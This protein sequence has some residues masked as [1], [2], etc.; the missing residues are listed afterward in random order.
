MDGT[1]GIWKVEAPNSVFRTLEGPGSD[2]NWMEW[3]PKG[4]AIVAGSED[5]T[6][7]VWDLAKPLAI[8]QGFEAPSKMGGFSPNGYLVYSAG[9]DGSV[10]VWNM[11]EVNNLNATCICNIKGPYFHNSAILSC[12]M[13]SEN[14]LI[15]SGDED[16]ILCVSKINDGKVINKVKA[17]DE[18]IECISQC[19]TMPLFA[20]GSLDGK[21][22]IFN[23]SD[24]M[25][26]ISVDLGLAT[27]KICWLNLMF[28]SCHSDGKIFCHDARTGNQLHKLVGPDSDVLDIDLNHNHLFAGTDSAQM[29][30]YDLEPLVS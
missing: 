19:K 13:H 3:H 23:L 11:K 21:I 27:I 7:W 30:L 4:P 18:G 6:I 20:A 22:T 25:P 8:M 14:S 16:G 29:F 15:I 24:Y 1:I 5:L 12:I 17:F 9:E 10:K 2:I 28:F 26:R